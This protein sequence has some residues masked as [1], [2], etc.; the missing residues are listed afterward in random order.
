MAKVGLIQ[1]SGTP[2]NNTDINSIGIQEFCPAANMNNAERQAMADLQQRF[3]Q[4]V[5]VASS[6]TISLG[7]Q[8]EQYVI[9]SGTTTVTSLGT[10]TV[11]SL[12]GYHVRFSGACPVTAGTK[13]VISGV[14]S[15]VTITVPVNSMWFIQCDTTDTWYMAPQGVIT[16]GQISGLTADASPDITADYFATYDA[17]ADAPK[18]VLLSTVLALATVAPSVRQTVL[19][20][21]VDSAGGAAFGGSTGSGTVTTATTLVATAANGF[22]TG[23]T[24]QVN[25]TG[26]IVNPSWTGLTTNGTMY[27]YL[28]ISANGSCVT[29]S[30]TLAPV[31]QWG[32][33][34]S[35]TNNQFTYNI[36]ECVAKI[37]NGSVAAQAYRV[38]VG[39]VTVAGSVTTAITWYQLMGRYLSALTSTLPSLGSNTQV[40]HNLG[41]NLIN[42]I[43]MIILQ[44]LTIDAGYAVGDRIANPLSSDGGGK[45][46]TISYT[47][48]AISFSTGATNYQLTPQGGGSAVA[49][50]LNR[51]AYQFQID[52]GW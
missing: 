4:A 32:G 16:A 38:Y 12:F 44:C 20:G 33:T 19:S 37:G 10:P 2:A 40:S 23:T 42:K 26:S 18:K 50:T 14:T 30:G 29:G 22:G 8:E 39:E 21:A 41:T 15:G 47:R 11:A 52:R 35:T 25:L 24:G 28:D 6:G 3:G 49:L 34:Y 13:L 17:S 5:T 51:W 45:P 9:I 31:Y 27:L 7:D 1:Y 43:P 36:Q 48:N 46:F